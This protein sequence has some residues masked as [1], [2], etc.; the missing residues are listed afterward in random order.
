MAVS[1]NI[2]HYRKKLELTQAQL[3]DR[4]GVSVQA[5]SKWET[6]TGL[7]DA[8]QLV[9]LAQAL[10]IS[11]DT[12]L[13]NRDRQREYQRRWEYS[14]RHDGEDPAR[15]QAVC[16]EILEEDP[17]NRDFLFRAAMNEK[18]LAEAAENDRQRHF[19]WTMARQYTERLL[20]LEPDHESGKE[21]LVEVLSAL[22]LEEEAIAQAYRCANSSRAL[23]RCLK[24]EALRR[25]RQKRIMARFDALL[26]EIEQAGM[27]EVTEALIRAA[28]PDGNDQHYAFYA[29]RHGWERAQARYAAGD[30]SGTMELLRGLFATAKA[31]DESR[32][33]PRFT[34][35]IFDLLEGFQNPPG[36]PTFTEQFIQNAL[37]LFPG[38]QS[39]DDFR[40][41]IAGAMTHKPGTD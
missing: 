32:N 25:H 21:H 36:V 40:D 34:A 7:P 3:A 4:L 17:E 33:T 18:F 13:G 38:L 5:V 19:H 8:A 16:L 9:P 14:L 1:E 28:I 10:N 30:D 20:R 37:G 27:P 23:L 41:L 31:M 24:G 15:Q 29:F 12:L 6:G 35:Q 2:R 22:W 39:R 11:T 26:N